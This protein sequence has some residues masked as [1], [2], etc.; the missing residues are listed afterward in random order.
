MAATKALI[1]YLDVDGVLLGTQDG[2]TALA[3]HAEEFIDFIL[4]H[5]EALW[6][7][8]HC[9]GD[10]QSVLEYLRPYIR[11]DLLHK[12]KAIRPT[13]FGVL[14]TEA[15]QGDFYWIDDQPLPSTTPR[16]SWLRRTTLLSPEALSTLR[17]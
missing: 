16:V 7:T 3:A 4:A 6:L 1:L 13:R 9:N 8:T 14:K 11:T 10:A 15:L 2:R 12:L 17:E 5:F